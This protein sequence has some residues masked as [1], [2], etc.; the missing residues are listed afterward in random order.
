MAGPKGAEITFRSDSRSV[1]MFVSR[2]AVVVAVFVVSLAGVVA[3]RGLYTIS[4][5]DKKF[6]VA[7]MTITPG[8]SVVFR[9]EDDITH[10]VFSSTKGHEFNLSAQK[11]GTSIEQAFATEGVSEVRCAFHPTMKLTITV[12]K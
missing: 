2:R 1:A 5:K 3:A 7:A 6:S 4:Q 10:N 12:K 11:P 9:N 8:E